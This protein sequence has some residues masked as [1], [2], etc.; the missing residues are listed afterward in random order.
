MTAESPAALLV[1]FGSLAVSGVALGWN[2]YRDLIDRGK[3]R[4]SCYFAFMASRQ[5]GVVQENILVWQ[6]TNYGRQPAMVSYVG[7]M[8]RAKPQGW[9]IAE[10]KGVKPLP[11]MLQPGEYYSGFVD[12]WKNA[13]PDLQPAVA[14]VKGRLGELVAREGK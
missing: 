12:L 5:E 10:M 13:D 2:V 11:Q 9:Q 4:V 14:T 6:V 8:R 7:G 1:S 3:L